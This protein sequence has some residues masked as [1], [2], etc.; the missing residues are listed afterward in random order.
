MALQ[1]GLEVHLTAF[2]VWICIDEVTL[3]S[4]IT[5]L[6]HTATQSTTRDMQSAIMNMCN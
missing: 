2:A 3:P 4:T 6:S 1:D 5:Y